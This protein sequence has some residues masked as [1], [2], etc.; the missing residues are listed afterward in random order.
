M[1]SAEILK[2]NNLAYR[3]WEIAFKSAQLA[4]NK[5]ALRESKNRI[6]AKI[7]EKDMARRR[8]SGLNGQSSVRGQY[9]SIERKLRIYQKINI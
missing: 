4:I 3:S 9:F 8:I 1:S 5:E 7:M 2:H 6:K